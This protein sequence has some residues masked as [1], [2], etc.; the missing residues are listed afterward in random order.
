MFLVV[1][2]AIK[3]RENTVYTYQATVDSMYPIKIATQMK[4]QRKK[5]FSGARTDDPLISAYHGSAKLNL[6]K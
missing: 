1:I 5:N 6:S 3:T 4:T 2:P